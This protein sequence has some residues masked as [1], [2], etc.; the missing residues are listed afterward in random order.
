M[1]VLQMFKHVKCK[2]EITYQVVL[3]EEAKIV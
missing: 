3:Y 1:K 2:I